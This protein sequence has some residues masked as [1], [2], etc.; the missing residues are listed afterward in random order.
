MSRCHK[1]FSSSSSN[2][3][4]FCDVLD[5][6]KTGLAVLPHVLAKDRKTFQKRPPSWKEAEE[7]ESEGRNE[8]NVTRPPSLPAFIMDTISN[9][10]KRYRDVKLE[11]VH[12]AFQHTYVPDPD[13]LKPWNDAVKRAESIQ[14]LDPTHGNQMAKELGRVQ[15]H[16]QA[17]LDEYK[18][19]IRR[20]F[21]NKR[22]ETRQD[23]L[24]K[25]SHMF[26]KFPPPT[27]LCFSADELA[28]VKASYAYKIDSKSERFCFSV[29]LRDL[30]HIK[31]QS[32]GPTKTVTLSFYNRMRVK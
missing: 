32:C 25:L 30:G 24:R 26:A 13:L 17:V 1:S 2:E 12:Q 19:T 9:E 28:H 10:A 23:I 4:R 11:Q 27:P 18:K 21:T 7:E 22:I 31:A 8:L 14:L 5:S 16:V 15:E 29:A 3:S 6:V 20:D